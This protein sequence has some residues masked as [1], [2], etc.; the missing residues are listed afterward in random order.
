MKKNCITKNI[1][2]DV[3]KRKT[4]DF[5]IPLRV[6]MKLVGTC[7]NVVYTVGCY[8]DKFLQLHTSKGA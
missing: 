8:W 7:T 2:N 3:N 6:S 4:N 1:R 5:R